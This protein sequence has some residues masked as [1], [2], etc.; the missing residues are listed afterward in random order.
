MSTFLGGPAHGTE[1]KLARA[2]IY[3]RV[4]IDRESGKVDALDDLNDAPRDGEDVH[5]YLRVTDPVLVCVRQGALSGFQ[6]VADYAYVPDAPAEQ[7]RDL[8]DW[9]RWANGQPGDVVNEV[10]RLPI[11]ELVATG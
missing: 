3:L 7:L 10:R 8:P 1:L 2:P 9:Q 4:A 6:V 11:A 5:V